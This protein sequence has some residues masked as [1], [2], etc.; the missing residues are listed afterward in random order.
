M[1][2]RLII[3]LLIVGCVFADTITY[4]N[5]KFETTTLTDIEYVGVDSGYLHYKFNKQKQLFKWEQTYCIC[6]WVL[7]L[8]DDNGNP[9]DYNCSVNTITDY[10]LISPIN[11]DDWGAG[12]D[13]SFPNNMWGFYFFIS[14]TQKL[15]YYFDIR[16]QFY[17]IHSGDSYYDKS[18]TWSE[19]FGDNR[20]GEETDYMM[21]DIGLIKNISPSIFL[22]GGAGNTYESNY[23]Q[24]YDEYEILGG[25]GRYWVNGNVSSKL[26]LTGGML[27]F[28]K[29]FKMLGFNHIKIGIHSSPIEISVGLG[30]TLFAQFNK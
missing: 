30:S 10:S 15:G 5:W 26:N 7:E 20:I 14:N 19:N 28:P 18:T 17:S 16:G 4:R 11:K 27:I 29:D 13:F 3:L 21:I 9:I 2:R 8:L 1:I 23:F 12:F 25:N 6:L 24:Y 22:Y